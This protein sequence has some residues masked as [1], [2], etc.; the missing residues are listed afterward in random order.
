MR[1]IW[2]KYKDTLYFSMAPPTNYQNLME[3]VSSSTDNNR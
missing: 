3:G 1:V 2:I